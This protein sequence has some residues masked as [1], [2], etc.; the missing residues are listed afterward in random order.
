VKEID[1]MIG[2]RVPDYDMVKNMKYLR[3]VLDETLR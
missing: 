1:E 2:D 3:A